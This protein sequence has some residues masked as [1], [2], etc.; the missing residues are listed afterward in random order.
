MSTHGF[1]RLADLR[2]ELDKTL[3]K[4]EIGYGEG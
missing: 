1:E 3:P 2:E 4:E